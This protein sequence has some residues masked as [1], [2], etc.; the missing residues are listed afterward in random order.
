ML[1]N[2]FAL[3]ILVICLNKSTVCQ[4]ILKPKDLCQKKNLMA[5]FS[6]KTKKVMPSYEHI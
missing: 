5:I 4:S 3:K 6:I 2:F 1:N